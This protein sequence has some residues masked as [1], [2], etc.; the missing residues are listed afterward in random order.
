M[1]PNVNR[2]KPGASEV[3]RT[4]T[5]QE[6]G[7]IGEKSRPAPSDARRCTCENGRRPLEV[8]SNTLEEALKPERLQEKT[9]VKNKLAPATSDKPHL[10]KAIYLKAGETWTAYKVKHF[11]WPKKLAEK[12]SETKKRRKTLP[13]AYEASPSE[14]VPRFEGGFRFVQGGFAE[15]GKR[16]CTE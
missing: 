3:K 15:L 16:R 1:R 5:A 7:D 13:P 8:I 10:S 2:C 9:G 14:V 6:W 4:W 12:V 11:K